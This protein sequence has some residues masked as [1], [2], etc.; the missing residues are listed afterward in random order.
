[1]HKGAGN[2][3]FGKHDFVQAAYFF[4]EGINVNSQDDELNAKLYHNR[5]TAHFYAG[6]VFCFLVKTNFNL[7]E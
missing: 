4:T 3:A 1:M 2:K 5:A 7:K 6:R